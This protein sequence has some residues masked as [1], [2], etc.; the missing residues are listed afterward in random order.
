[1][2]KAAGKSTPKKRSHRQARKPSLRAPA[3]AAT[4]TSVVHVI[5]EKIILKPTPYVEGV[6]EG[7]RY[8]LSRQPQRHRPKSDPA[9]DILRHLYPADEGKPPRTAVSD[10]EL[11]QAY[12]EEC[13]RRQIPNK[14]RVGRTQLLRCAGRKTT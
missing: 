7:I 5:E 9:I 10:F 1:M 12:H 8:M 11:E 4:R 2:P 3:E 13:D 6:K 14:A